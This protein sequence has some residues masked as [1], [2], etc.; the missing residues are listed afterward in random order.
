MWAL[1]L[2]LSTYASVL[3]GRRTNDVPTDVPASPTRTDRFS[4]SSWKVIR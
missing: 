1:K 3:S 4:S 2:L